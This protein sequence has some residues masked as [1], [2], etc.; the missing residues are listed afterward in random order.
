MKIL[1]RQINLERKYLGLIDYHEALSIMEETIAHN[2]G[3]DAILW[4]LE[5]PLVYTSGLKTEKSHILSQ[6]LKVEAARRGGSV[7]LHN[8]GQLVVYFVFPLSAVTGGLKRFVR[9]LE[10][11]LA[12]TLLTLGIDVHFVPGASGVF[13]A[14]GKIAFIGLGLKRGFIYHGIALNVTNDLDDYKAIQSCGLT[15]PMARIAGFND[16]PPSLPVVFDLF[17]ANFAARLADLKPME[18]RE[19]YESLNHLEDTA[20]AFRLGWLNFHERRYWEAHEIW[21]FFWSGMK[22]SPGAAEVR[23]F[24]HAMIQVAMAWYKLFTA[25]NIVGA[26]SLLGKALEK[27]RAVPEIKFL[28]QQ[29]VFIEFLE[30]SEKHIARLIADDEA[31]S[32]EKHGD[33]FVPP[34]MQWK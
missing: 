2:R 5:H 9:V 31:Y 33:I 6:N 12:E 29:Q 24:F 20:T 27:L 11:C 21:E 16:T 18:F 4:G 19:R 1:N 22:N 10:S 14:Q 23:T 13:T 32:V 3:D 30:Q 26:H 28:E 7:T 34:V 15:M 8:P 17:Y 25:P